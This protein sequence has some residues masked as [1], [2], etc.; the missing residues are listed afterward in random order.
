MSL[1]QGALGRYVVPRGIF[2][3]PFNDFVPNGCHN[4]GPV[5]LEV[6]GDIEKAVQEGASCSPLT[7][8]LRKCTRA[9]C[10]V[11]CTFLTSCGSSL[12]K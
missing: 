4:F 6:Q 7:S 9:Y 1:V 5:A 8:D 3:L 2:V 10:I 12:S 11:C